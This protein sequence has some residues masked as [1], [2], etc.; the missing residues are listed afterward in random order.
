MAENVPS[1]SLHLGK[2][3]PTCRN[4]FDIW[5]EIVEELEFYFRIGRGG[6]GSYGLAF[7]NDAVAWRTEVENGCVF[8]MRL[9][10][11][12]KEEASCKIIQSRRRGEVRVRLCMW[13]LR[14]AEREGRE[15]REYQL[16]VA[17][18]RAD[19]RGPPPVRWRHHV[20]SKIS[21]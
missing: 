3:C 21:R 5:D 13:A 18:K 2:L 8:C 20:S 11:S 15:K 17:V 7:H 14:Y 12:L 19:D 4:L 1:S 6:N 16:W 10:D 9:F